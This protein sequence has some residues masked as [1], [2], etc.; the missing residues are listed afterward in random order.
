MPARFPRP[1][2]LFAR[3]SRLE[4][5]SLL[6]T[7]AFWL[8]CAALAGGLIFLAAYGKDPLPFSNLNWLYNNGGD[9]LQ[10]FLG[11]QFF[12]SEPWSLP[13]GRIQAYGYPFGTSLAYTDSIPLLALPLKALAPLLPARFQYFG[14]WTLAGFCLQFALAFLLLAERVRGRINQLLGAAL[15]TLAPPMLWRVFLHEALSAHWLILAALTLLLRARR[16]KA[17]AW[18]WAGLAGLAALVHAY[19]LPLVLGLC[20]AS[21]LENHPRR[22]GVLKGILLPLGLG[23]LAAAAGG[24]ISGLFSLGGEDLAAYGYGRYSLN[25]N[26]LLNPME[27]ARLLP[28]LPVYTPGQNEGFAYLG[29]GLLLLA[30]FALGGLLLRPPSRPALLAGLRRNRWLLGLGLLAALF[31]LST[32]VTLGSRLLFE[33]PLLGWLESAASVFRSS[34]RFVWLPFYLL[35]LIVLLGAARWGKF[36]ALILLAALAVQW[37]D[38]QPL[39]AA[40]RFQ[41]AQVYR[42]PLQSAF[43]QAAAQGQGRFEHL[44]LLPAERRYAAYAPYAIYAAANRQTLNWGY[45]ARGAYAQIAAHGAQEIERLKAG[46]PDPDSLYIFCEMALASEIGLQN[47]LV[48]YQVDDTLLGFADSHPL[49]SRP[50]LPGM[51]RLDA[52][53]LQAAHLAAF[54]QPSA[55]ESIFLISGKDL[56]F[57]GLDERAIQALRR[58]GLQQTFDPASTQNY[59]AVIGAGGAPLEIASDSPASLYLAKNAALPF[60]LNL[61]SSHSAEGRQSSIQVDGREYSLNKSGLN[62][63]RYDRRSGQ[64][65]AQAF[66]RSYPVTCP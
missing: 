41:Q 5:T 7:R 45:F 34:G 46:K 43:W 17:P 37:Y 49:A 44:V 40:R 28:E 25:L 8:V 3:L 24:W 57:A 48:F 54:L 12:R 27:Y 51:A 18:A 10:H 59:I 66:T 26:A 61:L 60:D 22:G 15:L 47:R 1:T 56:P 42:S 30:A 9:Q 20:L 55:P 2:L 39:L 50:P 38:V 19:F 35:A 64:V 65:S 63:V 58:L 32:R 23:L 52:A 53:R 16:C 29:A 13:P 4:R 62:L 31:A 6:W 14:V 21:L 33:L 11:W 36:S